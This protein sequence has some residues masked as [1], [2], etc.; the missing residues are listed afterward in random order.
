MSHA[1]HSSASHSAP[2]SPARTPRLPGSPTPRL[3]PAVSLSRGDWSLHRKGAIDQQRHQRKV[4]EA[5]KANLADIVSEQ[6]LITSDGKKIVRVPIRTLEEYKF[7]FDRGEQQGVGAGNGDSKVGDVLARGGRPGPGKG[8]GAGDQPGVEYYEADVTMDEIAE[9]VFEDLG[10]P[11][12]Q[13]KRLR[14]LESDAIKFTDIRKSGPFASLDKKQTIRRNLQRNARRGAARFGELSTDDLRF[15]TWEQSVQYEANGV[16]LAMMDVSGSMGTNEK[17]LSRAFYF[18]MVRFLRTKYDRVEIV[19]IAH[20]AEAKEVTEE[21]FFTRGE[22]GGT[23]AST[24]YALALDIVEHRY[25]PADWN[26]YPFHFS[27]GDNWPSDN[28]TARTL[29]ERLANVSSMFGY[30]EIRPA[31]AGYQS[32]LGHAIAKIEHP[33]IQRV[34]LA[35]RSD[36]YPALR[37]FFSLEREESEANR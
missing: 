6:S 10:L 25:P 28:E 35:D 30:G 31:R 15:R 33:K 34:T 20:H 17:Y 8:P 4:R 19:F 21:E 16:V 7:R 36:V 1:R 23:R 18:W 14:E 26:I 13:P 11:N 24:A 3:A 32:S 5:L 37:A 12:L 9:L 27:D 29:V 2:F 22:S